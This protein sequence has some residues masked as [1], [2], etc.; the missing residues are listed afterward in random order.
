MRANG[1]VT[2]IKLV[3]CESGVLVTLVLLVTSPRAL[4]ESYMSLNNGSLGKWLLFF[5]VLIIA[6]VNIQPVEAAPA[7]VQSFYVL[8]DSEKIIKEAVDLALNLPIEEANPYSVFSVVAYQS[9]TKIYVDQRGNGY[10]FQKSDFT[11]ADAVFILNKGGVITFDNWASPYF[12]IIG[13]GAIFSGSLSSPGIDGGDYFFAAGGPLSVFRGASD[14]RTVTGDGNYVAGMW[15]LYPVEQGGDAAQKNYVVPAGEDTVGTNDFL[16]G[17]EVLGGTFAVVQSTEDGTIVDFTKKGIP[18][19]RSLTRGESF[20]IPNVDEG[21][22]VVANNKIQVGLIASGGETY[23]IRYFTLKGEYPGEKYNN[24]FIIPIFPTGSSHLDVRYHIHAIT[25]AHVTIETDAGVEPGWNPKILAPG[26]TDASF[27]TSGDTPVHIMAEGTERIII[28]VS[29]DSGEGDWDWGYVPIDSKVLDVEY[30]VPY[31]PSGKT[32]SH[33]MQ[34]YVTPIYDGTPI[35]VDYNQDGVYDDFVTLNRLESHG[36]H[37]PIDMDNTGTHLWSGFP[38]AVV[39]GESIDAQPGGDHPGYDWG[40]TMVP[41]DQEFYDIVLDI[42]KTALPPT[43]PIS[44]PVMFTL[45]VTSGDDNVFPILGVDVEDELPPGFTY[46]GG[47]TTITHTDDSKSY[48]DPSIGGQM[49]TWN[50]DEDMQPGETITISFSATSTDTPGENYMD[51]GRAVGTDTFGNTYSPEATAFVMVVPIDIQVEKTLTEPGDGDAYV[52]DTVEFTVAVTNTGDIPLETVPLKDTYDPAKLLFKSASPPPDSTGSGVLEWTD[53]TDPPG[54]GVLNPGNTI[55]VGI[56]FEALESTLPGSTTDLAEVIKAKALDEEIY[57]DGSD[58]DDVTIMDPAMNVDK[59][60]TEPPSGYTD[61]GGTVKFTVTITNTGDM[62]I[63]TVPLKD[64][65]DPAKLGYIDAL[66]MPNMVDTVGGVLEWTDLGSLDL[67]L[68]HVVVINFEALEYT[69]YSGTE[70]L[71][72]VIDAYVAQ[73]KYLSG[74]DTA[75][76]VILSPVGG[77]VTLTPLQAASPYLVAA[78]MLASALALRRKMGG[79]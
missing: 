22:T 55:I 18:D 2:I 1:V 24:D 6:S 79:L 23:D 12:T 75:L 27:C 17:G 62:P 28:L 76:V 40:Y 54:P 29:V 37:D 35:W 4:D 8:G 71:A 42:S 67:G 53:L 11:G 63:V 56:T 30:Y 26:T 61:I 69:D 41:L 60:L 9:Q 33:D 52:K 51:T 78:L 25:L 64:T 47:S 74:S 49:L 19:S 58:D 21:D 32:A 46:I 48:E 20:V 45:E 13:S 72:E 10:S 31:A 14:R 50:L 15:E 38:F 68:A 43:V 70:D 77:E 59:E 3:Y 65:Y 39:Y 57:V 36:F 16:G 66:P 73:D 34:L 44:S 5:A 7:G